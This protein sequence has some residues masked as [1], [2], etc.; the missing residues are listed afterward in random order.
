VLDLCFEIGLPLVLLGLADM[1]VSS[2]FVFHDGKHNV[3]WGDAAPEES[4]LVPSVNVEDELLYFFA[5]RMSED[6]SVLDLLVEVVTS[7]IDE[8]DLSSFPGLLLLNSPSVVQH[9]LWSRH[10]DPDRPIIARLFHS[11]SEL[12]LRS[13]ILEGKFSG[14]LR[15]L[16]EEVVVVES[17]LVNK[18]VGDQ[19]LIL[20][21][22]HLD[23]TDPN[24]CLCI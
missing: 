1:D 8:V 10:Q 14:Y 16:I 6:N 22:K 23:P 9:Q 3:Y 15:V 7:L 11:L 4:V 17:R 2:M 12:L 19:I 20:R 5:L 21:L 18:D 13:D 24:P